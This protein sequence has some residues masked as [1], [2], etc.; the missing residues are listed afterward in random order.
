V[1]EHERVCRRSGHEGACAEV[2]TTASPRRGEDRRGAVVAR[3]FGVD[4]RFD[5]GDPVGVGVGAGVVGE[6]GVAV[7][8]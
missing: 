7:A 8:G 1:L 6:L 5:A 3:R 4:E 2:A